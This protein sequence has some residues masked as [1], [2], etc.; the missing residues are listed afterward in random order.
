MFY[1]K[2]KKTYVRNTFASLSQRYDFLSSLFS[3]LLDH[4][5]RRHTTRLLHDVP[6]GP[7]L[8]LCAGTL[9]LSRE[10]A[11]QAENRHVFSLDLCEN[12]LKAGLKKLHNDPY[13]ARIFPICGDGE[14]IPTG[15][16]VFSGCTVAFGV[17][18]LANIRRGLAEIYRVLQPGGKLLI[19]EF[20]RPTNRLFRPIYTCYLHYIMPCIAGVCTADKEAYKYLARSIALFYEPEELFIMMQK[21]GFSH[22][23]RKK[24]TFGIVSIYIGIK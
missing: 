23:E 22:L 4:S 5:W 13:N 10:L 19:L 2:E 9:S 20:S 12:M 17:R 11:C 3:L 24:L 7:V 8:D 18:N 21:A 15:K 1:P 16:D 14:V 6:E